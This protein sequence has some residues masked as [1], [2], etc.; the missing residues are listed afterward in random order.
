MVAVM[1]ACP[2]QAQAEIRESVERLAAAWRGVG[3]SVV[4]DRTR[5]LEDDNDDKNLDTITRHI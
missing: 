5:F 2:R 3:A 1:S 4:V